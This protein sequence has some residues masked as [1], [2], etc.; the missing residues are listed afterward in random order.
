[1]KSRKRVVLK[2]AGIIAVKIAVLCTAGGV[3]NALVAGIALAIGPADGGR[4]PPLGSL[5][6]VSPLLVTSGQRVAFIGDSITDFG[7]DMP[8]GYCRLVI[9]ALRQHGVDVSPLYAGHG[10]DTSA[11]LVARLDRDVLAGR[12][13]WLLLSCGVNDAWYSARLRANALHKLVPLERF[14][15][16]IA[17]IVERCGLVGTRV[18]LLTPTMIGEDPSSDDNRRL[19]PYVEW[20][21]DFARE[22]RIPIADL[23]GLMQEAVKVQP[24]PGKKVAVV[25]TT[26][27]VH[28]NPRGFRMMARGVLRTIGFT[29]GELDA[30]NDRWLDLPGGWIVRSDVRQDER[31]PGGRHQLFMIPFVM[32]TTPREYGYLELASPRGPKAL[33]FIPKADVIPKLLK[34]RGGPYESIKDI[35]TAP[36]F[37]AIQKRI[38][39]DCDRLLAEA[40]AAGKSVHD[41]AP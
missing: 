35:A 39:A 9:D 21:K 6:A 13:D 17:D 1:M 31:L 11:D 22:R 41:A 40:V 2:R 19:A 18:M 5:Q 38:A 33:H 32:A 24:H 20:M 26:D 25:C 23:N 8:A 15:E 10:G 16:N 29:A 34:E 28:M 36:E 30:L 37:P 7:D 12:P 4:L 27:G 3:V 14:A